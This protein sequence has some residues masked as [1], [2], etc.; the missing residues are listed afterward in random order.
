MS[1]HRW[2]PPSGIGYLVT[3]PGERPEILDEPPVSTSLTS[4]LETIRYQDQTYLTMLPGEAI[5]SGGWPLPLVAVLR[6][7]DQ[8]RVGDRWLLHVS[9]FT[10]PYVGPPPD[11]LIG[12]PCSYC[13]I[14]FVPETVVSICPYC[15]TPVHCEDAESASNP[16]VGPLECARLMSECHH[17]HQ[18]VVLEASYEYVPNC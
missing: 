5:R 4:V 14:E 8:V 7:R 15:R 11:E 1:H 9:R 10:R 18:P 13:R 17:C 2:L 16:E 6:V 3:V 12:R